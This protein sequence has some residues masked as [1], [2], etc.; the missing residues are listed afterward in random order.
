MAQ[1]SEN[2]FG[3]QV[4]GFAGLGIVGFIL[5]L[6]FAATGEDVGALYARLSTKDRQLAADLYVEN[7]PWPHS[8]G[9]A[10]K[11]CILAIQSRSWQNYEGCFEPSAMLS[12]VKPGRLAGFLTCAPW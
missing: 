10:V 4:V 12:R 8:E 5:W 2:S 11:K 3:N 1:S 7:L 9:D 6:A